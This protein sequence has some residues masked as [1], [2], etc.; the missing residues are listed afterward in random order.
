[1]IF[2]NV[3]LFQLNHCH[4]KYTERIDK[5]S[6][7]DPVYCIG[8]TNVSNASPILSRVS[9]QHYTL[10]Y[11]IQTV[12]IQRNTYCRS[13]TRLFS[14]WTSA[15]DKS[16]F[17]IRISKYYYYNRPDY[18]HYLRQHLKKIFTTRTMEGVLGNCSD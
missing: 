10:N 6:I 16:V 14:L 15:F 11:N 2:P 7:A 4:W 13:L 12:Q 1:M 17:I 3:F 18:F 5:A 8:I 9:L